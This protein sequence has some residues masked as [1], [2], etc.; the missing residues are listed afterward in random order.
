MPEGIST[1][2][3]AG[4]FDAEET[5]RGF[6]TSPASLPV[7]CSCELRPQARCG[8]FPADAVPDGRNQGI[9]DA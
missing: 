1:R 3:F 4:V 2:G 6:R 9:F 8:T 5:V 7:R